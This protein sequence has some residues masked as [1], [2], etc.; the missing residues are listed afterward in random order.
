MLGYLLSPGWTVLIVAAGILFGALPPGGQAMQ[1]KTNLSTDLTLVIQAL[2]V[3]FIAAPALIR[4]IY[5]V[6][7]GREAQQLTTGWGST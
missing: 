2:I 6:K 4:A 7:T 3:V 1:V 5:R